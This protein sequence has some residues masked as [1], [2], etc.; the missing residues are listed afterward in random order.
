MVLQDIDVTFDVLLY[1]C[2]VLISAYK[3]H[4]RCGAPE[5]LT[6]QFTVILITALSSCYQHYKRTLKPPQASVEKE[7]I[8][9]VADVTGITLK[10]E[11]LTY[12]PATKT[13]ALQVP[14]IIK[15]EL[16]KHQAAILKQLQHNLGA[17]N[18]PK[19]V[20]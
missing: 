9:V 3:N 16:R 4:S 7:V 8:V 14:S 5:P 13:I 2:I 11:Q 15:T 6:M 10:S 12:T 18:A 17:E 1:A 20:L 19:V